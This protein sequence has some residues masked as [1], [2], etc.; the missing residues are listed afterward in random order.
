MD[1]SRK[2]D[3]LKV[4]VFTFKVCDSQSL[5]QV[6]FPPQYRKMHRKKAY[7]LWAGREVSLPRPQKISFLT[8]HQNDQAIEF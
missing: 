1:Q 3:L 2:L 8:V 6:F 7:F 4:Q 5:T